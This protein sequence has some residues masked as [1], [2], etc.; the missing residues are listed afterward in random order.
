[1]NSE[2]VSRSLLVV[3]HRGGAALGPENTLEA[4]Q[5]GLEAGADSWELDTQL[6][7]DGVPVL[8]HDDSLKRTTNAAEV[9]PGRAPWR[10]SD[11]TLE[12]VMRLDAGSWWAKRGGE[13]GSPDKA[14]SR[15]RLELYSSGRVKLPTLEEALLFTK[16]HNW[17]VNVEIKAPAP[18]TLGALVPRVL[19][20][21]RK[22]GT[23]ERVVV[24]CFDHAVCRAVAT[25]PAPRPRVQV[26]AGSRLALPHVYV[27]DVV[28]AEDFNPALDTLGLGGK[29][30][31]AGDP[32]PAVVVRRLREAGVGV[33]VWTLNEP[34]AWEAALALGVTAII[35]DRPGELRAWL[36]GKSSAR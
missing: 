31:A 5:A 7:K 4:A 28:G 1:V 35:T 17:R 19:D 16:K 18:G 29:D 26:L 13:K 30:E 27:K 36:S 32:D 2:E 3:A 15:E 20:V 23:V 11:F 33:N 34:G 25:S 22:T 12:E 21:I 24:S 9:F 14:V 8:L 6:T 10:L